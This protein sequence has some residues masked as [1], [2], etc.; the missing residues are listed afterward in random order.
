MTSP[1]TPTTAPPASFAVDRRSR[2]VA[3]LTLVGAFNLMDRQILAILL[4]PIARELGA[5]DTAMGLLTGFAFVSFY[6]IA[7][8]PLARVADG[9]SRRTL[10]AGALAFWS[11]LT[12]M[13]GTVSAYWQLAVARVG[14]GVGEA[15][16]MPASQSIVAD[17]FAP[18]QR[19]LALSTL[20]LGAPIGLMLAFI[21]GG[22]LER[23]VGWRWTMVAVGL[24]GVLLSALVWFFVRE[25]VRGASDGQAVDRASYTVGETF[26]YLWRLRS[27]RHVTLAA[28]WSTFAAWALLVWS[29]S[30]LIRIHGMTTAEAGRWLGLAAGVGGTMGTFLGGLAAQR[31]SRRDPR[32]LLWVPALTSAAAIPCLTLFLAARRPERALPMFFAVTCLG[33][34]M[35]GPVVTATQALARVRMRALAAALVTMT[36]NLVGVGLGPF[37]V[38]ALS[39]A[40]APSVGVS[41]L[42]YALASAAL[43]LLG[44]TIHFARGAAWFARERGAASGRIEEP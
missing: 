34:A 25:P 38:G 23:A 2:V 31:L 44:A 29:P 32:W 13:S 22:L 12:M 18:A 24:P 10:I 17:L 37:V 6:T 27:L 43:A 14:V 16:T 8:L 9:S 28:A 36:Y 33:P 26:A 1:H 21:V 30:F 3:V 20:Q 39:D 35:L 15:A 19:T 40:L 11:G 4:D 7:G 5:S 42:R 41:S